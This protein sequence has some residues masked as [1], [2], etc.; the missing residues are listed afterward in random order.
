VENV[1]LVLG[2]VLVLETGIR[3]SWRIVGLSVAF[4]SWVCLA[5]FDE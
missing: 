1:V 3:E 4:I 5:I 2:L